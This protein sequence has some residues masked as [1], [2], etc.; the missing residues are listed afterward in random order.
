VQLSTSCRVDAV[1]H[2]SLLPIIS[3]NDSHLVGQFCVVKYNKKAYPG[4][5]LAMNETDITVECMHC[6]ETKYNSNRFFWPDRV[7]DI[8]SYDYSDILSLIPGPERLSDHGRAY[9]HFRVNPS[10]WN[11]IQMLL[12]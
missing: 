10:L 12:K 8:C 2:S 9:S 5:I 1:G 4:K 7:K 3:D 6:I 11:N